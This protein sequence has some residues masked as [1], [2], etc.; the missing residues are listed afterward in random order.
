MEEEPTKPADG[1]TER[2]IWDAVL[3]ADGGDD[4]HIC[5]H[6]GV[7][8]ADLAV[9]KVEAKKK[10]REQNESLVGKCF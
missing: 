6:F 5:A 4:Q 10:E 1:W 3:N 8:D 9:R 2:A 7:E